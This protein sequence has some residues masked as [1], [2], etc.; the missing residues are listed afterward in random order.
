MD[1]RKGE[2]EKHWFRSD[3]FSLVNG[4][5][6]FQTREGSVEG[7]Y[8]THQEAETVLLLYLRHSDDSL[9]HGVR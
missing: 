2:S 4:K 7:P 1:V 9:Y 6:F 3:R 8:D 5:W